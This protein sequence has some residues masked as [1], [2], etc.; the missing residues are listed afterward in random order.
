MMKPGILPALLASALLLGAA[1]VSAAGGAPRPQAKPKSSEP[2]AAPAAE[3]KPLLG[4]GFIVQ[5]AVRVYLGRPA[6]VI[7]HNARGQ[8][9]FHIET[10]RPMETIP[11][12]GADAGFLYLTLRAGAVELT[13]KLVYSGK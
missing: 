1:S 8:Q 7:L 10:S 5:N 4:D 11:L 3:A 12:Q 2:K 13:K 9:L 6:T